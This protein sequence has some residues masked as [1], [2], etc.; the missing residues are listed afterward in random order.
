MYTFKRRGILKTS[1][2]WYGAC[3]QYFPRSPYIFFWVLISAEF[4]YAPPPFEPQSLFHGKYQKGKYNDEVEYPAEIKEA[5]VC[6]F[7]CLKPPPPPPQC[8]WP[9]MG[10]PCTF[11]FLSGGIPPLFINVWIRHLIVHVSCSIPYQTD[12]VAMYYSC[13]S[14]LKFPQIMEWILVYGT[15]LC[16]SPISSR[17]RSPR[18]RG[19]FWANTADR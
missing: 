4:S 5:G 7:F 6:P 2:A 16:P 8:T 10:S 18:Q 14:Q 3:P 11:N 17:L 15:R 12:Y 13:H 1:D 19:G 9:I